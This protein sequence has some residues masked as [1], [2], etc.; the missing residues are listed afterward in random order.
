[1]NHFSHLF[2]EPK[3]EV[4]MSKNHKA[5]WKLFAATETN[6]LAK[7]NRQS[8]PPTASTYDP[9]LFYWTMRDLFIHE[10]LKHLLIV[11]ASGAGK[12]KLI[13]CFLQSVIFRVRDASLPSTQVIIS[14]P[15]C[16]AIP[17]LAG[18]GFTPE[19]HD[20]YIL[21]PFDARSAVWAISEALSEPAM[22]RYFATQLIPEEK[23]S[24]APYFPDSARELVIAVINAMNSISDG[25][26]W[27]FRD[28][29]CA[30]SSR[31]RIKAVAGR[32]ERS[33]E[34]ADRILEDDRHSAGVVS[35]LGSKLGRFEEVAALWATSK[36]NKKFSIPEFLS[37]P[38]V[39]ILGNDPV[40]RESLKPIIALLLKSL[41]DE[42]LRQMDTFDV[43]Q[44][45]VLDE[46]RNLGLGKADCIHDLLNMGRSKGASVLLGIQSIEGVIELYGK[47][48]TDDLLSQCAH[49][50]F[51]RAG[52]PITAEWAERVFGKIRHVEVS[53]SE[54]SQGVTT[55][56]ST[57]DRTLLLASTFLNIPFPKKGSDCVAI[58]DV[59]SKGCAYIT[60]RP[61]DEVLSWI[62]TPAPIPAIL[63]RDN[64]QEQ[65]LKTWSKEEEARFCGAPTP[66]ATTDSD[67]SR[68]SPY[69]PPRNRK[70]P[71]D[72][73]QG[74]F[75]PPKP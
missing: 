60:R 43:R 52:G 37:K 50:M 73:N 30:L 54:S 15:K 20:V 19:D 46:F 23:H 64:P 35:T 34:I 41:T 10:V 72:P 2:S 56:Y 57:Q 21:N 40:L 42:I 45:F 22:A 4:T 5:F 75:F 59:P 62:R 48:A 7:S 65:I 6:A 53:Y 28:L 32:H 38:G 49:K 13:Q 33:K 66:D 16:D 17:Y 8:T 67:P 70:P 1:M 26:P 71:E 25:K 18:L 69:L 58:S 39:L 36:S 11:G 51:L 47:E 9:N 14:D 61:F 12:T 44:I 27:G 74:D 29:L 31:E 68:K 24:T 3:H 63:R 55:Q